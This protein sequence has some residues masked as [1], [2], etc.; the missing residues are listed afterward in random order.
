[1]GVLK[2]VTSETIYVNGQSVW[3]NLTFNRANY[4]IKEPLEKTD[5]QITSDT[6]QMLGQTCQKATGIV[7]GRKYTAW[8]TTDIP[9]S[10]GPWKLHGLPGLILEAYDETGRIRFTCTR[11][12]P[13]TDL[14]STLTLNPPADA[15]ATTLKDYQ[16]MVT[17]YREGLLA[18]AGNADDVAVDNATINS[19]RFNSPDRGP[20]INYPLN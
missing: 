2:L 14:P 1:M 7:K 15:T 4:L 17:A 9:A 18:N 16:R 19:A 5:W 20:K 6:K 8:F 13:E 3:T 11:I 10:F 12:V